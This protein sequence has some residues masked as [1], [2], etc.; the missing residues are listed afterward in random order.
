V[1][2]HIAEVTEPLP[3]GIAAHPGLAGS[4]GEFRGEHDDPGA[5]PRRLGLGD[6]WHH[7]E[8]KDRG[9]EAPESVASYGG[10]RMSAPG[11]PANTMD[12]ADR[13]VHGHL[14]AAQDP[15]LYSPIAAYIRLL[16]WGSGRDI[17]TSNG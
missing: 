13:S 17:M 1:S 5:F 6:K 3:E 8:A 10:Y 11:L 12:T 2:L 14:H 4:G 7:A 15:A 9:D 16:C